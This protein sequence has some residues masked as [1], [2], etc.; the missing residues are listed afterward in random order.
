MHRPLG[1]VPKGRIDASPLGDVPKGRI[2]ASPLGDVP[3]GRIDAM[4]RLKAAS[5]LFRHRPAGRCSL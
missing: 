2:D 3:K 4:H 1:D 5:C